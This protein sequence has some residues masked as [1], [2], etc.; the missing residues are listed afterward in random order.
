MSTDRSKH[1]ISQTSLITCGLVLIAGSS[2]VNVFPIRGTSMLPL[3]RDEGDLLVVQH[4]AIGLEQGDILLYQVGEQLLAH[5]LL[6]TIKKDDGS[7]DYLTKGDHSN[8]PDPP[9]NSKQVTGKVIAIRRG[10]SLLSFEGRGWR[11]AGKAISSATL[12]WIG[13]FPSAGQMRRG[14]DGKNPTLSVKII[15]RASLI[16]LGSLL[17]FVQACLGRW[18]KVTE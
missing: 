18:E 17:W 11:M 3:I 9:I 15:N 1:P 6:K 8:I 4:T 12:G 14:V 2:Q 5:R 13:L 16:I 10:D 7:V